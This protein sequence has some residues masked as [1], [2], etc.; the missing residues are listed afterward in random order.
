MSIAKYEGQGTKDETAKKRMH[1]TDFVD[2]EIFR[3]VL[4]SPADLGRLEA[5][6][7]R[8][9][10]DKHALVDAGELSCELGLKGDHWSTTTRYRLADGTPDRRRQLTLINVRLLRHLAADDEQMALAGDQLIV[11]LDLRPSNVPSGQRMRIG[12]AIIEITEIPHN[13][14]QKFRARYGNAA[15]R[16]VNSPRGKALRLRGIYAQ[17]VQPGPVFRGDVIAKL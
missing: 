11:D 4:E 6:A 8:T 12:A 10:P 5:I 2:E 13:G 1:Q 17:V 7:V 15:L 14:C 16:L 3:E 9:A